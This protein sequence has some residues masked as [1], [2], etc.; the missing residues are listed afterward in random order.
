MKVSM[1]TEVDHFPLFLF[2]FPPWLCRSLQEAKQL[3]KMKS[4]MRKGQVLLKKKEEKLSQLESS[5]LEE[6]SAG[7]AAAW[8]CLARSGW[9]IPCL[10]SAGNIWGRCS[11]CGCGADSEQLGKAAGFELGGEEG[12]SRRVGRM[13]P[14]LLTQEASGPAQLCLRR[15]GLGLQM[16]AHETFAQALVPGA[17][18][19]QP[20]RDLGDLFKAQKAFDFCLV[21]PIRLL[22]GC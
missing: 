16:R 14:A 8:A 20:V 5:L 7:G 12:R 4:A 1:T 3:D 21:G 10:P 13:E 2:D 22:D 9:Q 18:S 19:A 15:R 11:A 17:E 6:V